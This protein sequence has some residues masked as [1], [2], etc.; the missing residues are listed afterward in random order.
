MPILW[1]D[2]GEGSTD[3][4]TFGPFSEDADESKSTEDTKIERE[5]NGN[6]TINASDQDC[7]ETKDV[8]SSSNITE[9]SCDSKTDA[10]NTTVKE[11]G[12]TSDTNSEEYIVLEEV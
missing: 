3:K 1:T 7:S 5:N 4:K 2:A 10:D 8:E 6:T 12:V 9:N 11:T